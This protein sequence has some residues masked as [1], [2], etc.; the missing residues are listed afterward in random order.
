MANVIRHPHG[1]NQCLHLQY[2]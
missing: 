1:V 2:T